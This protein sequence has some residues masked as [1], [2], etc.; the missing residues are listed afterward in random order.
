LRDKLGRRKCIPFGSDMRL[1]IR[2]STASFYYYP[3]VMV[4]C[5]GREQNEITEP[6]V[7]FEVLSAET[8]RIDSGE[9]LVNYR[10]LP[11]LRVYVLVNQIN[12]AVTVYRRAGDEWQME[13][14]GKMDAIL[15]LPEIESQLAMTAIYER[16]GF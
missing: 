16:L 13:F 7:I 14:L 10:K 4:D 1:R 3:D 8:D 11:S 9:K 6:V 2:E 15:E 12:P 5:S